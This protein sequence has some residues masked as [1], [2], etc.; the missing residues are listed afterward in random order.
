MIFFATPTAMGLFRHTV[1]ILSVLVGILGGQ[2]SRAYAQIKVVGADQPPY[3]A[4]NLISNVFLGEGVRVTSIVYNGVPEAVGYFTNGA[5]TIGIDRGIVITTGLVET[6]GSDV[7]IGANSSAESRYRSSS[8]AVAPYLSP[9]LPPPSTERLYDI[10]VYEIRFI[11]S[12]DTLRF[13]YCFASEEY[14]EYSCDLYNDVFGFFIQ[15]PGYPTPTNIAF[16]PGTN[17]PVNIRNIHPAY[18]ST[19]GCV[20]VNEHL[21]NVGNKPDFVYD[22][23]TKV[24]TAMAIVT[25][26]QEY[27]I[28]LAIADVKDQI[29]D[30]GVFLEAKSFGTNA[31]GLEV[32]TASLDTAVAEGC[33]DAALTFR[34]SQPA[35]EDFPI[36]FRILGT[37][38]NG[39]D[40]SAIPATLTIPR[41]QT[42]VKVPIRALRDN[43]TEGFETLI[44]DYKADACQRT[45][46]TMFIRD[47]PLAKPQLP[48]DAN[49]CSNNTQTFSFNAGP[50]TQPITFRNTQQFDIPEPFLFV[51]RPIESSITVSGVQ[52]TRLN[53]NMI[54]SVCIN[55]E[56][57]Y[58]E[59][60]D[61]RLISPGGQVL[62]LTSDN[63]GTGDNYTNTCF[64][65]KATR[66]ITSGTPPFTGNWVPEGAWSDLWDQAQPSNGVWKLSVADDTDHFLTND[67]GVL[68]NWSITFD[69][70]YKLNYK[71]FS[72]GTLPCD[73]CNVISV[74]PTQTTNYTLQIT[75]S[76]G[77][78]A[79]D[80]TVVNLRRDL[81][82]PT[83]QCGVRGGDRVVFNFGTRL[84]GSDGYEV[85]VNGTWIRSSDS[86]SHTVTG[87]QPNQ[88]V[89]IQVR[90]LNGNCPAASATATCRTCDA[91]VVQ[92]VPVATKCPTSRDGSVTL[93]PDNRNGPY[94]YQLGTT[95]NTT[96]VFSNLAPGTYTATV[97][98][99]IQCAAFVTFRVAAPDSL[100]PRAAV[101]KNITCTGKSDGAVT[102]TVSQGSPSDYTYKWNDPTGQATREAT[103]LRSG[104]YRVTVRSANGCEET[105]T[106]RLTDPP[107]LRATARMDSTR[108]ANS[109]DG[110]ALVTPTG[111]AG[112]YRYVWSNGGTGVAISNVGGAV[113]T[114]TVTDSRTCT[115]TTSIEVKSPDGP[116]LVF[117]QRPTTCSGGSDGRAAVQ[118]G[119]GFGPYTYVWSDLLRQ[120]TDR[121][122][123]LR[124]GNYTVTITYRNTCT[125]TGTIEVESPAAI[126]ISATATPTS[127][128]NVNDG[129]VE[130]TV[131]GGTAPYTYNWS[132]GRSQ[133]DI[134]DV[135]PGVYTVTVSDGNG[136]T[137][138]TTAGVTAPPPITLTAVIKAVRCYDGADGSIEVTLRGGSGD[139]KVVS[140]SGPFGFTDNTPMIEKLLA[141]EYVVNVADSR[142]CIFSDTLEVTQPASPLI[143]GVPVPADTVCFNGS[144]GRVTLNVQG[145]VG[146]YQYKWR[147]GQT[148][149]TITDLKPAIYEATVTDANGCTASDSTYIFQKPDIFPYP[150]GQH[151]R[152]YNG[153]DGSVTV[154]SVFYGLTPTD[155]TQ[156]TF[157][158]STAPVQTGRDAVGLIGDKFYSVTATDR[159]GCQ[160]VEKI[161]LENPAEVLAIADS[162]ANAR[163]VGESS[164]AA[165]IVG[166]GGVKPYTFFWS[167][168]ARNQRTDLG[169]N[170]SAGNYR[171]T[172]TDANGCFTTVNVP[173]KEPRA[174]DPRFSVQHT[175]CF[176]QSN[177]SVTTMPSGSNGPPFRYK[178]SNGQT[179]ATVKNLAA[180][181]Y[182]V[183]ITDG[184]GCPHFDSVNVNQPAAPLGAD[185]TTRDAGCAGNNDGQITLKGT[186]GTPPY[187][188]ALDTTRWSG[189]PNLIGLRAGTY[190]PYILDRNGCRAKLA[191]ITLKQRQPLQV[192][193]GPDITIA[194]GE[195]TRLTPN[196]TNAA[197]GVRY[198]WN[199]NDSLWLS[200]LKCP[201]P[202]VDSLFERRLFR[203]TATDSMGCIAE[204]KIFINVEKIR[205]IYVPTGWTPNSDRNN[206]LLLV[207]GQNSARVL[208]FRVYDRWGEMVYQA[209]DFRV[210]DPGVGWDGMFR[211]QPAPSGIYP[212]VLEVEFLDGE[213][214]LFSGNTTLLR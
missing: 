46:L 65:P 136:C 60:L 144:D 108:C 112:P 74:R 55:V 35:K 189:S 76:Y 6:R 51:N 128:F 151:P 41:G 110:R 38:T 194:L 187:R 184:Q 199:R 14:P 94:T 30:S 29:K 166:K 152:C 179:T 122:T 205:K 119:A 2:P 202:M 188:F 125:A 13:R 52:P 1:L 11:P 155:A 195:S 15:G 75:D 140:W 83:V 181:R 118:V 213:R 129:K 127:C 26:C 10:A 33:T 123:G 98:D 135:A 193:L 48:P 173:I 16:I 204:A 138:T 190:M 95:T 32:M 3:T 56:H 201:S 200:C 178:W 82:A 114:V 170:L 99:R 50:L 186:G 8:T 37:A 185:V 4:Q 164:G 120:T 70:I 147:S 79:R 117:S 171:V 214:Q 161:Y 176:G 207:H 22:G 142:G 24:F 78:T 21:Y 18:S 146:P 109:A 198:E 69:P 156:F 104:L 73:T 208:D 96:G 148:T 163:C 59:D 31:L 44:V 80:T 154:G 209:K 162:I 126:Q 159:D 168:E 130:I 132:N 27:T 183:T 197:G 25:P 191:A 87:R 107:V 174:L 143:T 47:N 150:E 180:A 192:T 23:Y 17:L 196:A 68:L 72:N 36:D 57:P 62:E 93:R 64:T 89:T 172:L 175:L 66:K 53:A 116:V 182:K 211:G 9:L 5:S 169:R 67:K 210:N 141:G 71:W 157:V 19:A 43:L 54:R 34:L 81:P 212:W 145:G 113:Y 39:T 91:P 137:V 42:E 20:A 28:R 49:V 77:C 12:A 45:R 106:V 102:V 90:G 124:A 103:G 177:G 111:G 84:A 7:G 139:V 92:A 131:S 133:R 63:G 97:T 85:N 115:V 134:L 121:A 61:I 206:D 105:D 86:L 149:A 165:R 203:V 58:L 158:W 160:G 153:D 88:D 167:P 100:K 101:S 40:Y